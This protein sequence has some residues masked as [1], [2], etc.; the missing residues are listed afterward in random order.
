M[1]VLRITYH[2]R[3][4][5]MDNVEERVEAGVEAIEEF[6]VAR[7]EEFKQKKREAAQRFK[8]RRAAE[9]EERRALSASL[10]E[11]L[12]NEG[13]WDQLS[14]EH[15]NFLQG[16][17]SAATAQH[18]NNN[19]LFNKIFGDNPQVGDTVTLREA[20]ERTLKGKNNIDFYVK[21]WLEKGI[22]VSFEENTENLMESVYKIDSLA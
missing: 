20:F 15:K 16:M 2:F 7:D 12:K 5:D 4:I 21:K 18:N 17:C 8:E 1:I 22:V 6:N 14:D 13:F 9:K 19:S 3:G 10:M 11:Y